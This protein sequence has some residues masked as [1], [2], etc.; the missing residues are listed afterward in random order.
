MIE[1]N[2]EKRS[3]SKKKR[4]IDENRKRKIDTDD[5]EVC[6]VVCVCVSE[7]GEVRNS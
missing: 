2:T 1:T 6:G 4:K 7:N 3:N 5:N